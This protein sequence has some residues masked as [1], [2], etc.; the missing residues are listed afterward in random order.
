MQLLNELQ[1]TEAFKLAEDISWDEAKPLE[2]QL[3][4]AINMML[5]ARRALGIAN[6]LQDPE[7][8]KKHRSRIMGMLNRLSAAVVRLHT[9]IG[10]EIRALDPDH[11]DEW[12]GL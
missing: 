5:A 1:L 9:A 4:Q 12:S 10:G 6:R 7:A 11:D 3:D 2:G 8:R